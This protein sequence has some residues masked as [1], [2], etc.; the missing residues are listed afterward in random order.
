[1]ASEIDPVPVDTTGSAPRWLARQ[2][3]RRSKIAVRAWRLGRTDSPRVGDVVRFDPIC[4]VGR[5]VKKYAGEKCRVVGESYAV[6]E[7]CSERSWRPFVFVEFADGYRYHVTP[8]HL[9]RN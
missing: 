8:W 7:G 6:P 5:K 4:F 1:M 9:V 2:I 3:E